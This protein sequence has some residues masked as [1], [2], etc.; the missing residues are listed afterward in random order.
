MLGTQ[1][2]PSGPR[3]TAGTTQPGLRP[4]AQS[5]HHTSDASSVHK[6]SQAPRAPEGT[7]L[8]A[9]TTRDS[10]PREAGTRGQQ[11][12][13][14]LVP[15]GGGGGE[16]TASAKAWLQPGGP[17]R[18]SKCWGTQNVGEARGTDHWNDLLRPQWDSG[19]SGGGLVQGVT[20]PPTWLH[21]AQVL[22]APCQQP[23]LPALRLTQP[24]ASCPAAP[25]PP[26]VAQ[27]VTPK[28]CLRLHPSPRL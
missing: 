5:S 28:R 26:L 3:P 23:G 22:K 18:K 6:C 4:T 17:G 9:L 15:G 1:E 11:V 10:A 16:G 2:E 13:G 19:G 20:A 27:R 25:T 7:R 8:T 12:T 14:S 24:W 21:L